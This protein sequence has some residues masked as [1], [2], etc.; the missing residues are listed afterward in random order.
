ML[1]FDPQPSRKKV[2][3]FTDLMFA[4]SRDAQYTSAVTT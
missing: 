3:M 2:A 4:P 1:L